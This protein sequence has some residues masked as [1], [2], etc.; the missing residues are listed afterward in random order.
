[1]KSKIL[2]VAGILA[3][4]AFT[5][6]AYATPLPVGTIGGIPTQLNTSP[7]VPS[8]G[9]AVYTQANTVLSIIGG[10]LT[11]TVS[12][13][14]YDR[15]G[16]LLDFYYQFHN[17]TASEPVTQLAISKFDAFTTEVFFR[18]DDP[19]GA[20]TAF[21]AS[22]LAPDNVSRPIANDVDWNYNTGLAGGATSAVL[23]VR[24]NA[25]LQGPGGFFSAQD[26]GVAGTLVNQ[27]T[28]AVPEPASILLLG[29]GFLA[30]GAYRARRAAWKR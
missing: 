2:V 25:T 9:L 26:G 16:G 18:T 19:D 21:V 7:G 8:P 10:A 15:G 14:I 20:G 24:T 29:S 13:V 30:F 5:P 27:P 12:E 4:M 3:I 23:V 28:S 17:T 11:G 1:M 6:V 22:S